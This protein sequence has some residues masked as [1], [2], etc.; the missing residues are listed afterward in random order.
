MA[1]EKKSP[2]E[3]IEAQ[4]DKLVS[5]RLEEMLKETQRKADKIIA[6]AQAR[7]EGMEKA[8]E[9]AEPPIKVPDPNDDLEQY[10]QVQ[11][12]KDGKDYKDD[13]LVGVNG[14]FCQVKRGVPVKIKKKFALVL[15]ESQIQSIK[16]AEFQEAEQAKYDAA[17]R[18]GV[19]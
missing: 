9:T 18:L 13:V 8:A 6:D 1:N 16:S 17:N 12:F 15:E 11:L 5:A 2:E 7:A 3:S 4:V 14:Q 10:V 19:L